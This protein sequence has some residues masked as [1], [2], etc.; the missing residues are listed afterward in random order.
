MLH[1][2]APRP[3]AGR[4]PKSSERNCDKIRDGNHHKKV[5]AQSAVELAV[6]ECVERALH[7]ASGTLPPREHLK[8]A[9]RKKG[10]VLGIKRAEQPHPAHCQSKASQPQSNSPPPAH[11]L[12]QRPV[13]APK[14][15]VDQK[16]EGQQ[17]RDHSQ[18][19]TRDQS[20]QDGYNRP[21]TRI[22]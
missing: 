20:A 2:S 11:R 16:S 6:E 18:E 4:I 21:C 7:P 12:Q 9:S 17:N 13:Q 22:V 15:V 19:N 8:R 5:A 1:P 14:I 10:I 3:H